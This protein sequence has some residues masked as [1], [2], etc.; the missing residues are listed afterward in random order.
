MMD[1]AGSDMVT[2]ATQHRDESRCG[3]HEYVRH[4]FGTPTCF[5]VLH[6]T[7][8]VIVETQ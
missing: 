3:T 6:E 7:M 5:I 2:H 4:G 1:W 8:L